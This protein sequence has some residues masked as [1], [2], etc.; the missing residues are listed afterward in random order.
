MQNYLRKTEDDTF[1]ETTAEE[2][3]DEL[4]EDVMLDLVSLLYGRKLTYETEGTTFTL[5]YND[6]GEGFFWFESSA[7][8]VES[9]TRFQYVENLSRNHDQFLL[10]KRNKEVA[11]TA[12]FD[13]DVE[14]LRNVLDAISLWYHRNKNE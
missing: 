12:D 13:G 5:S 7:H 4:C 10:I 3:R 1:E 8:G 6:D 11:L 2:L 14:G 9:T